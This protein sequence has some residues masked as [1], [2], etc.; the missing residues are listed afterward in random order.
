MVKGDIFDYFGI[1]GKSAEELVKDGYIVWT[2]VH[3]K[4]AFLGEGDTGT[5]LNLI[6]NGLR[7]YRGDSFGGWGGYAH[8]APAPSFAA[9]FASVE[10]FA[11]NPAAARSLPRAPTH[12]F[13]AAAQRD[14]EARFIWA[15]TPRFSSANHH[16]R[17]AVRG[18]RSL[19]AR[20]GELVKLKVTPS[21]PDGNKVALR[22]WR[23]DDADSYAGAIDLEPASDTTT[24]FKVPIDATAGQT[25]HIIAEAT[26]DG[27]PALTRYERFIVTVAR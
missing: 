15:T 8:D 21:D 5:F 19:S 2:P 23:W 14:F 13:L 18:S 24:S 10:G 3:E 16:P 17:L 22:W 27:E 1:A 20:P 7:G 4:G 6:D 11:A 12:P 26:D 9:G 25:I